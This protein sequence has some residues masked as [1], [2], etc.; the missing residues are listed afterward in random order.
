MAPT[1]L[2]DT[3][4]LM[5]L[6][7]GESMKTRTNNIDK[8][9][10]L[11]P[12]D[13]CYI[14]K[15]NN[16]INANES[17]YH[18]I[19]GI[20]ASSSASLATYINKLINSVENKTSSWLPLS[21]WK[22]TN[23]IYC[24][25]N[26][27]SKVDIRV[28]VQI[29]GCVVSYLIDSSK[30]RCQINDESLWRETYISSILRSIL[31]DEEY[32]KNCNE[33]FGIISGIKRINIF[34]SE[35]DEDEFL[36]AA[37]TIYD[38]GKY[39]FGQNDEAIHPTISNNYLTQAI[40]KYFTNTKKQDKAI[41]F[42]QEIYK[43]N[44]EIGSVI[45]KLSFDSNHVIEGITTLH[46]AVQSG[47][48][49]YELFIAQANF[50]R[51][52]GRF[53]EALA[54]ANKAVINAITEFYPWELLA[55]LYVDLNEYEKALQALNSC[56]MISNKKKDLSGKNFCRP[57]KKRI[58]H[59][60]NIPTIHDSELHALDV[61]YSIIENDDDDNEKFSD[62]HPDFLKLPGKRLYGTY[63]KAY[64][65]LIRILNNVGWDNLLQ[66]RSKVFI[67]EEE[68]KL[69]VQFKTPES[70]E[71][72][73]NKEK[74][75]NKLKVKKRMQSLVRNKPVLESTNSLIDNKLSEKNNK[76][77]N[78]T[79]KNDGIITTRITPFSED[80]N[81]EK[82]NQKINEINLNK[83]EEKPKQSEE[84]IVIEFDNK[85]N[86]EKEKKVVLKFENEEALN[87]MES[88]R[89]K[90]DEETSNNDNGE[91]VKE[92][93]QSKQLP[94]MHSYRMA[95]TT[96]RLCERWLDNMFMVL[97]ED[98]RVFSLYQ[99]EVK[100]P[101][102]IKKFYYS[103]SAKEWE[104]YGDLALRLGYKDEALDAYIRSFNSKY[105]VDCLV[106]IL[107]I[108]TE[109][110]Q[111]NAALNIIN[112]LILVKE[113]TFDNS[114]YPNE[115]CNSL[116]SLIDVDGLE[117]V[118][119]IATNCSHYELI[120]PYFAYIEKLNKRICTKE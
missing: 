20:N 43:T 92:E 68:Y 98:L 106:K 25:Y 49:S 41:K 120:K 11:G 114:F 4:E 22:I 74:E 80:A 70:E 39:K 73:A 101:Y 57:S 42:F 21:S 3:P 110:K 44:P 99:V 32:I 88:L 59:N 100:Q 63:K 96:K 116:V 118:N 81:E 86:A 78:T 55:N 58:P 34:D 117:I 2:K 61:Y 109:F 64:K 17:S 54:I 111:I 66:Y 27:F 90:F 7:I 89:I 24:C 103:Q 113:Y 15:T 10:E 33:D 9:S 52:K 13:L 67:M 87:S 75:M 30:K 82:M 38:S 46:N 18:Y 60:D 93:D 35:E 31:Y 115:I 84:K 69:N 23:G 112:Q 62:V 8:I 26:I 108:H 37:K 47:S 6:T 14:L 83:D 50:L 51:E 119:N 77:T 16:K 40:V 28:E 76:N 91:E 97:Y 36:R 45:S 53:K 48:H 107:R 56:P 94:R 12:P 29:P 85:E 5:E 102:L 72:I 104:F 95:L 105:S 79:E 65:V 71:K 19:L 1:F